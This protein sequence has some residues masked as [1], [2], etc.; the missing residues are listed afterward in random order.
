MV[1]KQFV[2]FQSDM[3]VEVESS[4]GLNANLNH[5]LQ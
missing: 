3:L 2:K 4:M 5:G 1:I